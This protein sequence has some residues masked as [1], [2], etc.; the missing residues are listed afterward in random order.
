MQALGTPKIFHAF[1]LLIFGQLELL[2]KLVVISLLLILKAIFNA[3]FFMLETYLME[4]CVAE[5]TLNLIAIRVF[6][7]LYV[8]SARKVF[9]A[10][11]AKHLAIPIFSR[12]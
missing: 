1:E 2:F 4:P 6:F 9:G 3:P 12:I 11:E 8:Q 10:R 5:F 7:Q